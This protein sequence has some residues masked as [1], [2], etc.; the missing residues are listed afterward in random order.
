MLIELPLLRE[1]GDEGGL[2]WLVLVRVGEAV[3]IDIGFVGDATADD[4]E[5]TSGSELKGESAC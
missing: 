2:R 1:E 3:V 5:A 4:V